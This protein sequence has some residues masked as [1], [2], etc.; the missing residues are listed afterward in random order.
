MGK[1]IRSRC[2]AT[3]VYD[4]H[5]SDVSSLISALDS[6]HVACALS[7]LHDSDFKDDGS[8]KKAHYHL[9]LHFDSGRT[10]TGVESALQSLA[11]SGLECISSEYAY[12]RYLTHA[13]SPD[14]HRYDDDSVSLFGGYQVPFEKLPLDVLFGRFVSELLSLGI[15]SMKGAFSYA[16]DHPQYMQVICDRAYALKSVLSSF[17]CGSE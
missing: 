7:P 4:E 1:S 15:Y 13:D 8:L 11:H 5:Y 16:V 2:W 14:K 17:D 9:L 12:Y 10:R 6:L 3:I